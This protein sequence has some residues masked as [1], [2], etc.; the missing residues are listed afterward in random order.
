MSESPSHLSIRGLVFIGI[1]FAPGDSFA[2]IAPSSTRA[3]L[4]ATIPHFSMLRNDRD[5]HTT[6]IAQ[7]GTGWKLPIP[8]Q[9]LL[10]SLLL[11]SEG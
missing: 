5:F 6:D 4:E 3:T 1:Y 10:W 8:L 2:G 7:D 9:V 11:F